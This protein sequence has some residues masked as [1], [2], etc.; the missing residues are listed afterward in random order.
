MVRVSFILKTEI[1]ENYQNHILVLRE[2]DLDILG[3][4]AVHSGRS[5]EHCINLIFCAMW[6]SNS[7]RDSGIQTYPPQLIIVLTRMWAGFYS[8]QMSSS[9]RQLQCHTNIVFGFCPHFFFC[10]SRTNIKILFVHDIDTV[11]APQDFLWFS[12]TIQE[13][14]SH[15]IDIALFWMRHAVA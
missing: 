3:W 15:K 1:E 9:S 5:Q 6:T 12:S 10:N 7:S 11:S 13:I 4:N 8:A 2:R 14:P